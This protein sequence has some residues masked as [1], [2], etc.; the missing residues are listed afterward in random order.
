MK[1]GKLG[2][3]AKGNDMKKK[4]TAA[5]HQDCNWRMRSMYCSTSNSTARLTYLCSRAQHQEQ[6][7]VKGATTTCKAG[8]GESG[9][10]NI[11]ESGKAKRLDSK[12][13][14]LPGPCWE[15]AMRVHGCEQ[16]LGRLQH[17]D[18]IPEVLKIRPLSNVE[19]LHLQVRIIR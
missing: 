12:S 17:L 15:I 5:S 13:R 10:K 19:H 4:T 16:R 14:C 1:S 2:N 3:N 9:E 18:C 7:W 6:R 11:P 8:K